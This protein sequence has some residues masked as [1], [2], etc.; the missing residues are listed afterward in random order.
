M[1]SKIIKSLVVI[2][3]GTFIVTITMNSCKHETIKIEKGTLNDST[4][5]F[6]TQILPIFQSNCATTQCHN[7]SEEFD[8]S[9]YSSIKEHLQPGNANNSE[10]YNVLTSIYL[11]VMPPNKPL[12]L[13][14]RT[15]IKLWIDQGALNNVPP[16]D[17]SATSCDTTKANV[18]KILSKNCVVCHN[19]DSA[20]GGIKLVDYT[21]IVQ[22]AQSGLLVNS[23][24]GNG[25]I[26]MPKNGSLSACNIDAIKGWVSHL[27]IVDPN[28]QPKV[29]L[30]YACFSRD[31]LPI[32]SSNCATTGCHDNITK[33]EGVAL[34]SYAQISLYVKPNSIN[35][36]KLYNV[37]YATGESHMPPYNKTQLTQKNIDSIKSWINHGAKNE[38]CVTGCDSSKYAFTTNVLPIID[39]NCKGCHSGASPGG[40]ITLSNYASISI[41]AKNGQLVN[42]IKGNGI[43]RMPLT[44][45]LSTC[46]I[47]VIENWV[48][49]GSL[50]N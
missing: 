10:I 8:L 3:L 16:L 4:I 20:Q 21:S 13:N 42:S 27:P 39:L 2:V 25:V 9:Q 44:G 35:T 7:G 24:T 46:D 34:T 15:L 1:K 23:I 18:L 17:T 12:T 41:V 36:S 19:N 37:L 28:I 31:I 45:S 11:G 47:A 30:G 40:N 43:T 50:N 48:K 5:Y 33:Q 6:S 14:Q 32:I 22:I 49:A 26:K 29:S 38:L